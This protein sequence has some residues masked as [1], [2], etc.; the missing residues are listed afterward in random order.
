MGGGGSTRRV[1]FEADENENIT[2]VKGVRLSD[3]VI[4]RMKEP[5]SPSGRQ[6]RGSVNDEELKKRIAEELAL[7]RARR[8]SEAQK[9]RLKQEQMYVRDEFGKLLER[10]RISSN[11]HLTRAIL[12]ERAATE[13]ERQ[14]AQRFGL[15]DV[16]KLNLTLL[17]VKGGNLSGNLKLSRMVSS[18]R[19]PESEAAKG[20]KSIFPVMATP[21]SAVPNPGATFE[22]KIQIWTMEYELR[23]VN[24]GVLDLECE[25]WHMRYG[26]LDLECEVFWH[27]F[28]ENLDC[29]WI[30]GSV[31]GQARQLEEKEREL[32]KHDAY[33]KEQLARLE[34]RV[35]PHLQSCPS[36]GDNSSSTW[37]C[38]RDSRG[39]RGA[40]PGLEPL[41][42]GARL[43]ELGVLTWREGSRESFQNIPGT[44]GAPGELQRD[45]GQGLEGQD[46]GNGFRL[47]KG[48]FG[49]DLGK[50]FL[51]GLELPEK[52]WLPLDPWNIQGQAGHWGWSSLGQWK[53]S[54][55]M[56]GVE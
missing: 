20:K 35:R 14:K 12:R 19:N 36:P 22:N 34:E 9:R 23:N 30:P 52:L 31:Q 7:E 40:A 13:E 26:I 41:C 48:R 24:S 18:P 25:I 8:D 53:V 29:S 33:Y 5:S 55:P 11:E 1:T 42:S 2:V 38:W 27:K 49:W 10:E 32:K 39:I 15:V 37:S 47:E 45:W 44:K 46:T 56:V 17:E 16:V 43:E 54:L 21:T 51:P 6:H 4:D 3:S 28:P 50:E